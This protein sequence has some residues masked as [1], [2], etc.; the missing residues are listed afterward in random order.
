MDE[1]HLSKIE[2]NY[3]NLI[4]FVYKQLQII[5]CAMEAAKQEKRAKERKVKREK[6]KEGKREI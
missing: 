4:Q 5:W 6:K 3:I 1:K 2:I